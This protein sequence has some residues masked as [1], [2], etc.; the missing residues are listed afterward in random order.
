MQAHNISIEQFV[1]ARSIELTGF[2]NA[3]TEKQTNK[4]CPQNVPKSVRR[5]AMSH[6]RYRIPRK[7]RLGLDNDLKVIESTQKIP[8]CR[9]RLRRKPRLMLSYNQRSDRTRWLPL[10]LWAAKRMKLVEYFGWKVADRPNDKAWRACYRFARYAAC[11]VDL[12]YFHVLM[13]EGERSKHFLELYFKGSKGLLLSGDSYSEGWFIDQQQTQICP[14][15]IYSEKSNFIAIYHPAAQNEIEHIVQQCSDLKYKYAHGA[16]QIYQLI[17][18]E[19]LN[20]LKHALNNSNKL[21]LPRELEMCDI[22]KNPS[23]FHQNQVISF[24][25]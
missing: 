18:P 6:N 8:V 4:H 7:L 14:A 12:S 21:P 9:K 15:R 1:E 25:W 11:L 22:V 13:L 3:L 17:G 19:S 20:K 24:K 2:L 23:C 16:F 10:H 5:R